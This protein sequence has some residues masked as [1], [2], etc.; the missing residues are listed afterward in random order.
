MKKIIGSTAT[1]LGMLIAM[2]NAYGYSAANSQKQTEKV[3]EKVVEVTEVEP[4]SKGLGSYFPEF[5]K[6]RV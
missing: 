1:G 2:T 3:E 6:S 5:F 4:E